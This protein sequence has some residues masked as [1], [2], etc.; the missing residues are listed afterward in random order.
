M[1]ELHLDRVLITL[2]EAQEDGLPA[3]HTVWTP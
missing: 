3:G 1:L 2:T